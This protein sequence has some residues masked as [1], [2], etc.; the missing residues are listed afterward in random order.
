MKPGQASKT[1]VLVCMGR[2]LADRDPSVAFSDPTAFALLPDDARRR[3][4][5]VESGA[6]PK[7]LRQKIQRGYLVRQ[8]KVMVA[9]T[10]AIDEAVRE[11]A[12]RQVVILGAGLDGRAWRMPELAGAVVFEVDHPDSQREKR[13]RV[14]ELK[15]TA[16]EVRFVAVD[17][18]RDD[19]DEALA[20][21][22]HDRTLPTTWIWE[23]VVMYLTLADIE[24]T[25]AVVARR[26]KT[27]SRLLVLY[28]APAFIVHIV[29][30]VVRRVGEPLR[31]S[32][33]PE[34][35]R[36]LLA[37]HTFGVVRDQNMAEIGRA[38]SAAIAEATKPTKHL[39][40]AVAQRV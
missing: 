13:A 20:K 28:H 35:M 34:A 7:G 12:H 38:I 26:S 39:R 29:G 30:L 27:G 9:R 4:E 25:L 6:A 36:T 33:E 31:S 16:R 15:Q 2:A 3:V 37:K 18:T 22:G 23:G 40:L 11:A 1:A 5:W 8:S 19:L 32:F 17:F 14:A 10:S 21:A 24:A